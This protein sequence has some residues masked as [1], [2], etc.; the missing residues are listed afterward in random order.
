MTGAQ[1]KGVSPKDEKRIG[2]QKCGSKLGKLQ[3]VHSTTYYFCCDR[4]KT[5]KHIHHTVLNVGH[6]AP[7]VRLAILN[8]GFQFSVFPFLTYI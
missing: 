1:S 3:V 8:Q 4:P 7:R 6:Q 5:L 2:Q